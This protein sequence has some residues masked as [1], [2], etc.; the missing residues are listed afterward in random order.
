MARCAGSRDELWVQ[1]V[2]ATPLSVTTV[3]LC[4][5]ELCTQC[6]CIQCAD[7]SYALAAAFNFSC[8]NGNTA[9]TCRLATRVLIFERSTAEQLLLQRAQYVIVQVMACGCS[10]PAAMP[11]PVLHW[12]QQGALCWARQTLRLQNQVGMRAAG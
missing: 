2:Q 7:V 12:I 8:V 3:Q 9:Q 6:V 1:P 10:K 5:S 11:E 4:A